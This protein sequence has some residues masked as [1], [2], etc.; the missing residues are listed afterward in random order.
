MTQENPQQPVHAT[1]PPSVEEPHKPADDTEEVY[2]EGS[3]LLRAELGRMS[4]YVLVAIVLV[5]IPFLLKTKWA[6]EPWWTYPLLIVIALGVIAWPIMMVRTVR[7][8]VSNYRIDFERGLLSKHIDTL[9][10]WHVEDISFD[11]SL[12]DRML[13]VGNVTVL[14]HDD[15][16]PKLVMNGLPNPRPL[17]ETLK[18]RVIAV[19]RQRGVIKMDT[20]GAMGDMSDGGHHHR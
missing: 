8:R 11:Q 13:N 16:T 10:L 2:F 19:K 1:P 18:Q 9:E 5:A 12:L 6:G 15:T 7:F 17:F 14:S 4:V 3:P 20:G